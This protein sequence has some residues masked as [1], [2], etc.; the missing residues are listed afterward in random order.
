MSIPQEPYTVPKIWHQADMPGINTAHTFVDDAE[1]N[2][3]ATVWNRANVSLIAAAPELL[4]IAQAV[5]NGGMSYPKHL[6]DKAAAAIAKAT[7]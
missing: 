6:R 7:R 4:A 3:I 2:P 1:G 5:V